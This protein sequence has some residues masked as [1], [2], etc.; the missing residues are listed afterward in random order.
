MVSQRVEQD[1]AIKHSKKKK[2]KKK[3]N[4]VYELNKQVFYLNLINSLFGKEWA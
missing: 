4:E 3:K 2:K 1:W